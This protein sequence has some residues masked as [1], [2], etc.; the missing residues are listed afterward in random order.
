MDR[1]IFENVAEM[2][3]EY[4]ADHY[5]DGFGD[6]PEGYDTVEGYLNC[7]KEWLEDMSV[8]DEECGDEFDHVLDHFDEVEA[9]EI[10]DGMFIPVVDFSNS[11]GHYMERQ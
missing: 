3:C 11:T 8:N 9:E 7:F 4:C 6:V 2:F 5:D 10:E 1:D